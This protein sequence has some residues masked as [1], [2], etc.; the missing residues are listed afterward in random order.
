MDGILV[1]HSLPPGMDFQE[2]ARHIAP[3]KD[4]DGSNPLSLGLL[5]AGRP[6]YVPAVALATRSFLEYHGI[7]TR[8]KT[9]VVVGRSSTVGIPTALLYLLRGASGDATVTIAHSQTP[10]LGEALRSADIVI[11]CAGSPGLLDR[12]KVRRGSIVLDVGVSIPKMTGGS[13]VLRGDADVSS[14]DG[15]AAAVTPVPGGVGP[16]TVAHLLA[17]TVS[18]WAR[19][20]E[21]GALP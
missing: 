20:I 6:G 15:W 17:S 13:G 11:S 8:G 2:I 16:V 3:E 5:A 18:S 12:S 1:A 9:L 4:V 21:G 19:R 7:S 14:L 10:D